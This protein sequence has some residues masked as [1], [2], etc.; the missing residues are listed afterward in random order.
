M[1]C[2]TYNQNLKGINPCLICEVYYFYLQIEEFYEICHPSCRHDAPLADRAGHHFIFWQSLQSSRA[3]HEA[4]YSC[5][6]YRW[7]GLKRY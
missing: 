2:Q 5:Q 4:W 1:F 6:N 7:Y 3:T